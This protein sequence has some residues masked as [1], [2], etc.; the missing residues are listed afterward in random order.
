M[1]LILFDIDGTLINGKGMGRLALERAFAEVFDKHAAQHPEIGDV[2][3]AG[4]TDQVIVGN[5]A[6]LYGIDE[7]IFRS[8]Y[9]E[10]EAAYLR[11]LRITVAD[12]DGKR[13]CPGIPELL[14][15]LHNHPR[16]QLALLTGNLEPGARIKLEP[17]DLNRY[18]SLGGFG[19][20]GHDRGD[21]ARL[22]WRRAKTTTGVEIAAEH[23]AVVGD[24]VYDV[25]A[26]RANGFLAVGVGTGWASR[27]VLEE[28]GADVV[29]DDLSPRH[30]FETWLAERWNLEDPRP[31]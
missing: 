15:R 3:I 21:M 2:H 12:S 18:F 27:E 9:A 23:V 31:L 29:F 6:R 17:F 8:R 22:A 4:S 5:M 14:E 19:S 16:I 7:P 10:F 26:G 28:A 1:H 13:P 25:G 24:T 20:D 11:H 30:G